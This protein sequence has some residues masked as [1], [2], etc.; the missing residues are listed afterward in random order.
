MNASL[1]HTARRFGLAATGLAT[2]MLLSACGT[3]GKPTV[4]A[5]ASGILAADVARLEAAAQTGNRTDILTA[6]QALR[7]DLAV[8]LRAGQISSVRGTAVLA[9]LARV[10]A[11]TGADQPLPSPTPSPSPS[12]MDAHP[13][14]GKGGDGGDGG[15]GGGG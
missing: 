9:Q 5:S 13:G 4:S 2:V 11:D 10:I 6:A 7:A 14:K 1:T 3:A 8:Q 15:G 12:P